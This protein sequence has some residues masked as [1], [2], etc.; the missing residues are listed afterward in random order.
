MLGLLDYVTRYK[1]SEGGAQL[2]KQQDQD[3]EK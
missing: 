3:G 2:H 1:I